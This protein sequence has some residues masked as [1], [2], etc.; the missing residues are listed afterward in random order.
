MSYEDRLKRCGLIS[1]DRRRRRSR[2]DMIWTSVEE[3][4]WKRNSIQWEKRMSTK[5]RELGTN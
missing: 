1:L 5:T 2:R 3:Y 4:H